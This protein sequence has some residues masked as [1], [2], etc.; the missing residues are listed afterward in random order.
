MRTPL[1]LAFGALLAVVALSA[2]SA[3][4]QSDDSRTPAP[5][6]PASE[7][8]A[9]VVTTEPVDE[10]TPAPSAIPACDT[11][12]TEG[13]VEAL[14]SEG[15]TAKQEEFRIGD[16]ALE[17]GLLCLWSDYSTASDHG[18][19]YAWAPLDAQTADPAQ[20]S[21]QAEGWL[22]SV[23]GDSVYFTEDPEFA[24]ATDENG[25]GMTYEFGDG[26]VKLADTKQG[27]VLIDW[28]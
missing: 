8:P 23:E 17:G 5:K 22:R 6:P 12:I 4:A 9:P 28:P 3:P 14:S 24:I 19:M 18:Q 21:L 7:S 2:C 15:W 20:R 10:M 16:T 27:L 25:F 26:W 13:T 1:P 11:I